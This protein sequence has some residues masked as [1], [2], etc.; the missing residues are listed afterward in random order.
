MANQNSKII[1]SLVLAILI[2]LV[3]LNISTNFQNQKPI[4]NSSATKEP[5]PYP[6]GRIVLSSENY[7]ILLF[8]SFVVAIGLTVT[9]LWFTKQL[10]QKRG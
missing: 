1:V 10:K 9:Y 3:L 8:A 6:N 2:P 5:E 7:A 4:T